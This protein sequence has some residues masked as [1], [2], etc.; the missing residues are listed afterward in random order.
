MR[1]VEQAHRLP[2]GLVF[3]EDAGVLDGHGP[4]GELP[5]LRPERGVLPL[6]GCSLQRHVR[7]HDSSPVVLG[8]R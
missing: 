7:I 2:D 1:E 4:S 3:R 6:Q 5:H 8:W